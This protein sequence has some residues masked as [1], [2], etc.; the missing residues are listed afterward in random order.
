MDNLLPPL[1]ATWR[2]SSYS[3]PS[4]S[5]CVEAGAFTAGTVSV[6]DSKDPEGPTL[7]F[8]AAS[9]TAF[10]TCVIPDHA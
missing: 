2:K 10:V 8:P 6:R 1:G 5:Y 7:V 9:W 3:Q 4:D